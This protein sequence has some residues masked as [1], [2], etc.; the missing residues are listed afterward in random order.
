MPERPD[1]PELVTAREAAAI[2][3]VSPITIRG[4]AHKGY[5]R[6]VERR[7]IGRATKR[8]ASA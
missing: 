8:Y 1:F 6:A 2:V 4:W 3:K 7:R 5:L